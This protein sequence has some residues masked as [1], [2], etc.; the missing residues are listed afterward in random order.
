M[1]DPPIAAQDGASFTMIVVARAFG[2]GSIATAQTASAAIVVKR[3]EGLWV[4]FDIGFSIS[5]DL[6]GHVSA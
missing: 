4:L 1:I 6:A 3:G 5:F 2:A